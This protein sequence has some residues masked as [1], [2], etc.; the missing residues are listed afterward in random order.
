MFKTR[1]LSILF[2]VTIGFLTFS[3]SE[4]RKI[5]KSTDWKTKYDAAM[6]YYS[7]EEYYKANVL[8]EEIIPIIKGTKEAELAEYYYAYSYYY[9]KQYI[10]AAHYFK[11]FATIYGRSEYVMEAQYM[12]AY[13]LFLESPV[14]DLDQS[15]TYEAI[16]SM[17][18]FINKY[19]YSEYREKAQQIIDDLQQKLEK[20]AFEN[21]RLYY[22]LRRYRS[23]VVA[24]NNFEVDYPDSKFNEEGYFLRI[25]CQYEYALQSVQSKQ[26][27]RFRSVLDFYQ[28]FVDRYTTSKYQK[29]AEQMYATSL[30]QVRKLAS[31]TSN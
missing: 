6:K 9:Q 22:K 19:P 31:I 23:G 24:F 10:L 14:S 3:C 1:L 26:E 21:S 13:S 16:A 5:Q 15:S 28:K 29:E 7:E 4:F 27:E 18:S 8:L 20:K 17:Q 12:H 11:T 2:V 25:K 30:D